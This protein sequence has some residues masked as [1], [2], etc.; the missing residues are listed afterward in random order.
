MLED[1]KKLL[2][3]Q[4]ERLMAALALARR[5]PSC[6]I[7]KNFSCRVTETTDGKNRRGVVRICVLDATID[8]DPV[9]DAFYVAACMTSVFE[10]AKPKTAVCRSGTLEFAPT[11]AGRFIFALIPAAPQNQRHEIAMG[12]REFYGVSKLLHSQAAQAAWILDH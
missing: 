4:F 6:Y 11:E 9:I 5:P 3:Q 1:V 8:L 10:Q 7:G 2:A 12:K